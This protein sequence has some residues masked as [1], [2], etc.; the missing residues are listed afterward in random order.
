[1]EI[2][3]DRYFS[4]MNKLTEIHDDVV[5]IRQLLEDDDDESEEDDDADS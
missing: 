2:E 1:M 3:A 4:I 5:A